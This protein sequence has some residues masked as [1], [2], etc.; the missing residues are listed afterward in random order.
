MRHYLL[1]LFILIL[2]AL[3]RMVFGQVVKVNE[4]AVCLECHSDLSNLNSKKSVHTAFKSGK[5]SSCHNPHA[6]R[7]AKLL[8]DEPGTLCLNCHNKVRAEISDSF[9][10]QPAARKE[11]LTCHEPHAADYAN[12]LKQSA[13]AL[14]TSCHPAVTEWLKRPNL[15]QPVQGKQCM[16]CHTPHGSSN[17]S[18]L[19]K[20]VPALCF[21]CHQQDPTFQ[22]VHKGYNLSKADCTT[23]HDPHSSSSKGL[24]MANQHPPFKGGK[25]TS[26]HGEGAQAGGSFAITGGIK[27]LCLKCHAGITA[28]TQ[29]PHHPHTESEDACMSCHNPHAS[30][31]A[32]LLAADQKNLCMKCHFN[33]MPVKDKTHYLTHKQ[34][35]CTNCHTPH[36]SE[37]DKILKKPS[38]DLCRDC[39]LEVHKGS[40]P[41]GPKAIDP[42]TKEPLYCLSCHKLHG[43]DFQYYLPLNPDGDLCVQ[44]HRK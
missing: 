6:S 40:H 36:G 10:H 13:V 43:S 44:C 37:N 32:S 20:D 2:L 17:S 29:L 7:H 31:S 41:M 5:C 35:E 42:R 8:A 30:N 3:P 16:T 19:V 1:Q 38:P 26:C 39:H 18:M 14:C 15:H 25:C 12:Q 33:D 23:C 22:T 9:P 4:P 28:A 24:L 34:F 11:C 21:K 27:A